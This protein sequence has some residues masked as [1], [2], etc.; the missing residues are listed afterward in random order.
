M[1]K[2]GRFAVFLFLF[3]KYSKR[4]NTLKFYFAKI[5]SVLFE[6]CCSL[7]FVVVEHSG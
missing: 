5:V 2:K 6:V 1:T 7:L 4:T 3:P